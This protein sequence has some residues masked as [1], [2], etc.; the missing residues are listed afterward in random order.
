MKLFFGAALAL[1]L[2]APALAQTT[3]TV[4]ANDPQPAYDKRIFGQFAE[5]LGT[6]IEDGIWVGRD[7]AIPNENGVR[8]DVLE[9]LRA[10]NV[11]VVRWPGG[12]FADEYHWREGIGEQEG[13]AV[14]INTHWGYVTE[15]NRFGTH[16]F[17][18]F[19]EA[20][21]AEP[22]VSGNIGSAPPFEMAE[23]VEYMTTPIGSSLARE[24]A[25]NGRDRP[26]NLTMFGLGNELWGCGG[27][28]RPEYAADLTR[29][30]STFVK[31][32]SG[33]SV[34]RIASGANDMDLNWT[35]VMME[36]AGN[37]FDGIGV[38]YYTIPYDWGHKGSAIGFDED[39]WAR[40]LVK[41][42]HMDELITAHSEVMD[43][44][45]PNR[46]V[47]LLIDEWG[48]WYD[49][50]PDTHPGFLRQQN[51][52]RDALVTS[53]NFDIF[54][55]HTERVRGANIAQMV[56]VLQAMMFT[57]GPDMVLTPTYHVF[58]LYQG[59]MDGTVYP[60]EVESPTYSVNEWSMDE[61]S[62]S[63]VRGT[64]GVLR[65]GLTNVNPH[66]AEEVTIELDGATG[67]AV[68]GRMVTAAAMDA[69]NTF[70]QPNNVTVQTFTGARIDGDTIRLSLP[71][72]SV[73]MLE[74][75]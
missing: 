20:L 4:N 72:K 56:N 38:H 69:H 9:A 50:D 58:D 34:M 75:R 22:Y 63:S 36:R 40:T 16:E 32:P 15:E 41:T 49:Q 21:G 73:V 42:T 13:R 61:V 30:Y 64:D 62:A 11:P 37:M 31:V 18:D 19:A 51:S 2:A 47:A 74:V 5:H 48:T 45:D 10:I 7:S 6:G 33:Q 17:M 68:T 43:R 54:A 27:N 57:D 3:V 59:Y 65:I 1:V 46:R 24:R 35:D 53:L 25:A 23:W 55:R 52:L 39:Q 26:W 28:M 14:R 29:R 70:D 8:T 71:A 60:V 44:H 67:S 12:C 66:D